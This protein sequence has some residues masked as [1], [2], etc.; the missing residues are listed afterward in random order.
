MIL[1]HPQCALRTSRTAVRYSVSIRPEDTFEMKL[2]VRHSCMIQEYGLNRTDY[3]C[4]CMSPLQSLTA[5]VSSMS[6]RSGISRISRHDNNPA[7]PT[8][9]MASQISLVL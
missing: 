6:V 8:P 1:P 7:P 2:T 3:L 4:S 5:H 9:V